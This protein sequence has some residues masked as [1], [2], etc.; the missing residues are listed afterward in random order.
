MADH[1]V[2]DELRHLHRHAAILDPHQLRAGRQLQLEQRIDAGADVEDAFQARLLVE[3]LLGRR[4]DHRV[5]R[6]R[7]ARLPDL[8]RGARQRLPQA[9]QPRLGLGVGTTK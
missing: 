4:P 2:A 7:R 1:G 6:L 5:V 3:E 8:D 9:L